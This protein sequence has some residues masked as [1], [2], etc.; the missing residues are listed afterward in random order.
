[1]SHHTW[2]G[3]ARTT[4][5][6]GL[7]LTRRGTV[8]SRSRHS[9]A[10]PARSRTAP[11]GSSAP[12]W[13]RPESAPSQSGGTRARGSAVARAQ[14]RS[15]TRP[16]S[17]SHRG[18][19]R[20]PPTDRAGPA[21]GNSTGVTAANVP[22]ENR[23]TARSFSRAWPRPKTGCVDRADRAV[24]RHGQRP[25]LHANWL[26]IEIQRRTRPRVHRGRAEGRAPRGRDAVLACGPRR[27]HR[28]RHVP[29]VKRGL[30]CS[31]PRP[32]HPGSPGSRHHPIHPMTRKVK[33]NFAPP[34]RASS[35]A[36]PPA[37]R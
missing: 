11:A 6:R 14:H 4:K 22:P 23:A 5:R 1:M 12:T 26:A 34:S 32:S 15:R 21:V 31:G 25:C 36:V 28:A 2:S 3:D 7:S 35:S 10:L 33:T 18:G 17:R 16:A 8:G 9:T 30:R 19:H 29:G 20:G 37:F 13:S 27:L 24:H